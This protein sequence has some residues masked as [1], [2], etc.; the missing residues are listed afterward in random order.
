MMLMSYLYLLYRRER[1]F[2]QRGKI[3]H[4]R[5]FYN[6][7]KKHE[8]SIDPTVVY[9]ITLGKKMGRKLLRKDLKI[10]SKFNT[11]VI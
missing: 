8:T 3:H 6:R 2:Y 4:F 1:N 5:C 11:Y 9:A 10:K 7:F